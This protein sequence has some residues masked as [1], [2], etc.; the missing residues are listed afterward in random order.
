MS[1]F[2]DFLKVSNSRGL[3]ASNSRELESGALILLIQAFLRALKPA[4]LS[5]DWN[6]VQ[7]LGIQDSRIGRVVCF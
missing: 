4:S 2:Y 5:I 3:K 1:I 7:H 6:P